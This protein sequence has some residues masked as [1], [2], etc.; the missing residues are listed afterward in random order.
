MNNLKNRKTGIKAP[1]QFLQWCLIALFLIQSGQ[2]N[3]QS[4]HGYEFTTFER[5][6]QP[7]ETYTS[8]QKET[9]GDLRWEY[10]FDLGFSLPLY[11]KEYNALI[12]TFS[13]S[14][15]TLGQE[16]Y[17]TL[18]WHDYNYDFVTDTVNIES[19]VRFATLDDNGIKVLVL[20]FV[21]NRLAGDTTITE[22]DSHVTF[23]Q[24]IY[25]DG[26]LEV[27]YG[28]SN[29]VNSPNYVPGVGFYSFEGAVN[30]LAGPYFDLEKLDWDSFIVEKRVALK[31]PYDNLELTEEESEAITI[32]PPEGFVIQLRPTTVSTEET[33][34]KE[35][36]LVYPNPV[37]EIIN[38]KTK[39]DR[40]IGVRLYDMLGNQMAV[41]IKENQISVQYLPSGMYIL[42]LETVKGQVIREKISKQ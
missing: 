13:S 4:L 12:C 23:Q 28:P 36:V 40:I 35:E 31:G 30:S 38:M 29:L 22:F 20:E 5:E 21:K 27:H 24:R 19:D 14:C 16:V 33:G 6:Y 32:Y 1:L 26:R 39:D 37:K 2:I 10:Q 34:W 17:F 9:R 18:N 41:D 15:S 7:L 25:E 11:G 3:A 8:M 42:E